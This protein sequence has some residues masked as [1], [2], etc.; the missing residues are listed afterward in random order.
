[1]SRVGPYR[2]LSRVGRDARAELAIAVPDASFA[3]R[4]LLRMTPGSVFERESA[5][6]EY[7]MTVKRYETLS[8]SSLVQVYS[9][10]SENADIVVVM[11]LVEGLALDEVLR[12]LAEEGRSIPDVAALFIGSRILGALAAA[13]AARDPQTSVLAPVVHGEVRPEVVLIP[14]DGYIRLAEFKA[15]RAA[16]S[17]RKLAAGPNRHAAPEQ[18]RE[19]KTSPLTDVYSAA[20]VVWELLTRKQAF[21][22]SLQGAELLRAMGAPSIPSLRGLRPD[23]PEKL[24]S[25]LD[26]ALETRSE[27]RTVTAAQLLSAFRASFAPEEGERWFTDVMPGLRDRLRPPTSTPELAPPIESSDPIGLFKWSEAV[28]APPPAL[29]RSPPKTAPDVQTATSALQQPP[30]S[31]TVKLGGAPPR[32]RSAS[33]AELG[34]PRRPAPLALTPTPAIAAPVANL[35]P[36][37][38]KPLTPTPPSSK[39]LTP[40]PP[41]SKPLTPTP[42]SSKPLTPTPGF[43]SM[44]P[45]LVDDR[46]HEV[47]TVSVSEPPVSSSDRPTRDIAVG[48]F[49]EKGSESI[50]QV[51]LPVVTPL[52]TPTPLPFNPLGDLP[53]PKIDS[54]PPPG[55][56]PRPQAHVATQPTFAVPAGKTRAAWVWVPISLVVTFLGGIAAFVVVRAENPL[57][58]FS[59]A[60]TAAPT[61]PSGSV[62]T[63]GTTGTN[64]TNVTATAVT[65]A[66][67]TATTMG[68]SIATTLASVT[69]TG[70]TL[71]SV[72]TTGTTLASVTTAP[73]SATTHVASVDTADAKHTVLR[74]DSLAP[75]QRIFVDGKVAGLTPD[76]LVVRCGL[77][78]VKIGDRG[79]ARQI[80]APCGGSLSLLK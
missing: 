46:V 20:L 50:T 52:A 11:E 64:V 61:L 69:A 45:E 39:P 57:H 28:S 72:T 2:L 62:T 27:L 5:R 65:S 4:V 51:A 40:T 14:W 35:A 77:H 26:S 71:A 79:G 54:Q 60:S 42:P 44:Q 10:F 58:A 6:A 33:S 7:V 17:Y 55:L 16:P 36:S 8:H 80:V 15:A 3:E 70:T 74:S 78:N 43:V 23:L 75:A 18:A 49:N 25:A 34:A 48:M 53:A 47:D 31:T 56:G 73:A 38:A 13:H 1:M 19:G 68:S 63:I 59:R 21:P 12:A 41:S 22:V 32:P 37:S 67:A 9:V 66:T 30:I 24:T 29:R 76:T